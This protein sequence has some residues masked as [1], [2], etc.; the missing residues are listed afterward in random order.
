M[1]TLFL[2]LGERLGLNVTLSTAPLHVFIKWTDDAG[3]TLNFEA[4]SGTFARDS[5][6]RREMPMTDEAIA[7]GVYM[8]MLTRK[9][10]VA[11]MAMT[12]LDDLLR[13]G[14]NDDAIAVAD[15]LLE[16]YPAHAYALAKKG[17]AYYRLLK[18]N[19]IAEYPRESD[20]PTEELPF[21]IASI[22]PIRR[23]S[24]KRKRLAGASRS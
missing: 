11:L 24:R 1:P 10:T 4:T 15:A 20:I 21:A 9:E 17:T 12:I 14:R 22:A 6:F 19:F 3:R 16:A 2:V 23:R 8:K 5:H 13:T 18:E 7:N